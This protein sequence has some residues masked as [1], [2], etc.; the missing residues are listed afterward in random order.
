MFS[1]VSCHSGYMFIINPFWLLFIRSKDREPDSSVDK[2]RVKYA[3]YD[4]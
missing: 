3:H 1:S 2:A 4:A